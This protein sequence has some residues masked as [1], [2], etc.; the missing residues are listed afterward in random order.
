M[1]QFAFWVALS[2]AVL[3]KKG[4]EGKRQVGELR[5]RS[6]RSSSALRAAHALSQSPPCE[7]TVLVFPFY[8][9]RAKRA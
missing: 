7:I 8:Q 9:W 3:C 1:M 5:L 4:G 6:V 2:L